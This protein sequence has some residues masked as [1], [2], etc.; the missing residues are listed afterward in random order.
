[1]AAGEYDGSVTIDTRI[2]TD[3]F[4]AGIEEIHK[5]LKNLSRVLDS[6]ALKIQQSFN[7]SSNNVAS[8]VDNTGKSYENAAEDAKNYSDNISKTNDEL[9]KQEN[10]LKG[11]K[12]GLEKNLPVSAYS[13]QIVKQLK[14]AEAEIR[15]LESEGFGYGDKNYEAASER[16]QQAIE[17]Y[18][19]FKQLTAKDESTTQNN[20]A[21][22]VKKEVKD[23]TT[24]PV[25]VSD[26]EQRSKSIEERFKKISGE[27]S[28]AD[29][30]IVK[31]HEEVGKLYNDSLKLNRDLTDNGY[32]I[33]DKEYKEAYE[34]L[35]KISDLKHEIYRQRTGKNPNVVNANKGD[36]QESNINKKLEQLRELKAK[37]KELEAGGFYFGNNEYDETYIKL[38]QLNSELKEYRATLVDAATNKDEGF[39]NLN[40]D[41]EETKQ[42]LSELSARGMGFGN[43]EYDETYIRLQQLNSELKKYRAT[44]IDTATNNDGGFSNLNRDVE[45]ARQK[46]SELSSRGMGFGNAEYDKAYAEYI[47]ALNAVKEYKKGL[48]TTSSTQEQTVKSTNHLSNAVNGVKTAFGMLANVTKKVF[49]KLISDTRKSHK[50]INLMNTSL[51]KTVNR[52]ARMAKTILFFRLFRTGIT[53]LRN[54]LGA[55]LKS[56]DMFVRSLGQV[57]A[58]LKTAF[59]PV[60]DT[61]M[62]AL[63]V[64]M[65]SLVKL[66]GYLAQITSLL[67]GKSVKSM[68][69]QSKALS[70]VGKSADKANKS[71]AKYD[72]L[73]VISKSDNSSSSGNSNGIED[74]YG[75]IKTSSAIDKYIKK[76]KEAFRA[77]DYYGV[78]E[79]IGEGI[80]SAINSINFEPLKNKAAQLGSNIAYILNGAI[81]TIDFEGIGKNI[82][83]GFNV[84]LNFLNN[85]VITFDFE[86]L[87]KQLSESVNGFFNSVDWEK[88]SATITEGIDGIFSTVDEF[89][90]GVDWTEIGFSGAQ[91]INGFINVDWGSV[92]G[93]ISDTLSG[94]LDL[95]IGLLSEID[96]EKL[97]TDIVDFLCGIDWWGLLERL[98]DVILLAL[99]GIGNTLI[100]GM[101]QLFNK[102]G[103]DS[104]QGLS[105]GLLNSLKSLAHKIGNWL[106]NHII[107]PVKNLLGIHSPSTVF[108]DIGK[109]IIEGLK[110]G[111]LEGFKIAKQYIVDTIN[112]LIGLFNSAWTGIKN[113]F[114]LSGI[115]SF[116]KS[117]L[118]TIKGVFSNVAIWF[119]SIFGKAWE[120]VKNVFSKGGKVFSGIVDGIAETFKGIVNLLIDGINKVVAFPFEKINKMLNSIRS[121][122]ILGVKPFKN[123]WS[124]N[125]ISVPAI[126]HLATGAVIPP[127]REFLAVLGDQK[128]GQ[129]I[130]APASLI[131]KMAKEA[132]EE[133]NIS[134]SDEAPVINLYFEGDG[135]E[136]FKLVRT[137]YSKEKRRKPN[138]EVWE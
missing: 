26:M 63:N 88:L 34:A 40:R 93:T 62:P 100:S 78:G 75:D 41:I 69:E 124:N 73:S 118:D 76:L 137:E 71:L 22:E 116:F 59:M 44:L 23:K 138:K 131:K 110:N 7:F 136:L 133:S 60:Y 55:L 87:G 4:N 61:I 39:N 53:N 129:N 9:K 67:F 31:L 102:I 97:G 18:H 8:E 120:G 12:E 29:K 128:H 130:E 38:Q 2:D 106:T 114:N 42:K 16:Y 122:D 127:N 79:I 70:N 108:A 35:G 54:Y 72:E 74:I 113:V 103:N 90:T 20:G 121:T 14:N 48:E 56:D 15:K 24:G 66:S 83:E 10:E 117:V 89:I 68:Q 104:I 105:E 3:A 51:G 57:K 32:C 5:S 119:E 85:F 92:A 30:D 47:N 45:D 52:I 126:P 98:G 17:L 123:L 43:A 107:Q 1:M 58:N 11:V 99:W 111:I 109:Y 94:L 33:D 135:A 27:F 132:I 81:A 86:K 13:E 19:K 25:P 28:K 64:L 134:S 95:L 96:W 125:P 82:A 91:I 115:G 50:G 6:V 112:Q 21:K 36:N 37:L 49:K 80:N 84:A 101:K 77:G 46:L 65:R